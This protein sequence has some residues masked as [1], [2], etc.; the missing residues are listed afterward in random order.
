[1]RIQRGTI[2]ERCGKLYL[3]FHDG[4][5]KRCV[6][7]CNVDADHW[8]ARRGKKFK[9]S[10]AVQLKRDELIAK[11]NR[12][13]ATRAPISASMTV[14]EFWASS[15]TDHLARKK[16]STRRGY[17]STWKTYL[18]DDLENIKLNEFTTVDASNFLTKLVTEKNLNS[19]TVNHVRALLSLIWKKAS[20]TI[21]GITNPIRDAGTDAEPREPIDKELR[22]RYTMDDARKILGNKD[23]RLEAKCVFA[24]AF[25][26]GL[27]PSE[28][29][30]LRWSD[31]RDGRITINRAVVGRDE[32]TTKT[33]SSA[34][35]MLLI[36]PIRSLLMAWNEQC[37]NVTDGWIFANRRNGPMNATSFQRYVLK[38]AVESSGVEWKSLYAARR[39]T[40]TELR[41][42]FGNLAVAQSVLRHDSLATTD[43]HYA[44]PSSDERDRGMLALQNVWTSS[45]KK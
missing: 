6:H 20:R 17:E 42:I 33:K 8:I 28:I 3:R 27:R 44:L 43:A 24:I 26:C 16:P 15:M 10:I 32:G 23:V 36:D 38:P 7:L 39:G 21:N 35:S 22:A 31:V 34:Q 18:R 45:P 5:K 13:R 12:E 40:G 11:V 19:N 1:M 4:T 14:G 41:T 2:V 9:M 37:G 29:C 25:F 30:G